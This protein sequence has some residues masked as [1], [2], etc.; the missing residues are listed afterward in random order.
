MFLKQQETRKRSGDGSHP[1]W[2]PPARTPQQLGFRIRTIWKAIGSSKA[3]SSNCSNW[4]RGTPAAMGTGSSRAGKAR[5]L[6]PPRRWRGPGRVS[7]SHSASSRQGP[8]DDEG[9]AGARSAGQ[10]PA[11]APSLPREQPDS[12]S[13]LLDQVLEECDEGSPQLLPPPRHDAGDFCSRPAEG[14]PEEAGEQREVL[15]GFLARSTPE[16]NNFANQ[17]PL[18]KPERRAKISYDYSEEELMATIEQEY[19]R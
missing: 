16:S 3:A 19:C 17:L 12:D 14:S 13:E 10:T 4:P 6:S 18:K 2:L 1:L 7:A 5:S 11:R 8:A 15:E 9:A